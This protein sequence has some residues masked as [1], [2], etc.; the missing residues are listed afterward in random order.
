MIGLN[1]TGATIR[2]SPRMRSLSFCKH[3]SFSFPPHFRLRRIRT[4]ASD[5]AIIPP[6]AA[7]AAPAYKARFDSAPTTATKQEQDYMRPSRRQPDELRAVSLERGV[8]KYA[9]GS[10]FVKFGD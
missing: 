3:G 2:W 9:E 6:L 4:P 10:C 5:I 8:V 1:T 7:S